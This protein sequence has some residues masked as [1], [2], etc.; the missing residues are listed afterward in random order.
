MIDD[1]DF[2][3]VALSSTRLDIWYLYLLTATCLTPRNHLVADRSLR[4]LASVQSTPPWTA[5]TPHELDLVV[6]E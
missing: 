4:S 6:R 3:A 5:R 1:V 2:Q